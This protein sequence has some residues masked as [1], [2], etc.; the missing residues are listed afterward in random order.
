MMR[1]RVARDCIPC[2]E[3]LTLATWLLVVMVALPLGTGSI[4]GNVWLGLQAL[5]AL[6]GLT[7][8]IVYLAIGGDISLIWASV[9]C[10][11]IGVTA[12]TAGA[13]VLMSTS[14]SAAGETAGEF[15]A[16]LAGAIIP[17]FASAGLLAMLVGLGV[18]LVAT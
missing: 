2:M 4:T 15:H 11:A 3:W 14:P 16:S 6:A 5:A 13:S 8:T 1:R 18:A 10:A 12:V 7:L 17:F 9:A